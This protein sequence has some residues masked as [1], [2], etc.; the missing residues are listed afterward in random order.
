MVERE[1][2]SVRDRIRRMVIEDPEIPSKD[3]I[4][5]LKP[6]SDKGAE[7]PSK[8]MVDSLR[9]ETRQALRMLK[10][11]GYLTREYLSKVHI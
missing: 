11:L 3:I 9:T 1:R 5:S 8:F 7:V 6:K 4:A 2:G 10:D